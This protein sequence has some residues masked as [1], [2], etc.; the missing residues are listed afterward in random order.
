MEDA[1]C[2]GERERERER[3]IEKE[4]G[5]SNV[6]FWFFRIVARVFDENVLLLGWMV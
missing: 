2:L 4:S 3:E 6:I 5:G 1:E